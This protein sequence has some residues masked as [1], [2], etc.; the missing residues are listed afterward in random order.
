VRAASIGTE[1]RATTR[2]S[3][4]SKLPGLRQR[5]ADEADEVPVGLD[6]GSGDDEVLDYQ[7]CAQRRDLGLGKEA[8][9]HGSLQSPSVAKTGDRN[10]VAAI[11]PSS[12]PLAA[13]DTLYL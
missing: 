11:R 2:R 10:Q 6:F 4:G 12:A 1:R 13:F 5:P 9:P 3:A 8:L 7:R